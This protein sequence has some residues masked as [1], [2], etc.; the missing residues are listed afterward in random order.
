MAALVAIGLVGWLGV[1][2][3]ARA[4]A[5]QYRALAARITDAKTKTEQT[6]VRVREINTEATRLREGVAGG[7]RA[8]P[9]PGAL[10]SFLQRVA[11]LA[12]EFDV[13][14]VQVLPQPA[15]RLDGYQVGVVGFSG[16]GSSLSFARLL[17]RLARENPY[18]E[19]DDFSL[20]RAADAADSRCTLSWTLRLYMLED[21]SSSS[22]GDRP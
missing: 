16:R 19:L 10:T 9:K 22:A 11:T 7:T 13:Q 21:E 20:A 14:I 5:T 1:L 17:D 2:T 3:P 18:F 12:Q 8:A 6:N 15:R 4:R